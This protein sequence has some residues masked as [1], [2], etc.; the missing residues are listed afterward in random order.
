[1]LQ[2]LSAGWLTKMDAAQVTVNAD[3]A[4][5]LI[6]SGM[7]P[8]NLHVEGRLDLSG[9]DTR[10]RLPYGLRVRTLILNECS[11]L[12]TLPEG[13]QCYEIEARNSGLRSLPADIQ[14]VFKID[15]QGCEH[16]E[17]LPTGLKTGALVL[18]DCTGLRALPE[19]LDVYFLDISGC[20]R[21][22]EWPQDASISVG[23]LTA[24]GMTQITQLPVQVK[25]LAQLDIAGCSNLETLPQDLM[26][27]S[28]VDVAD[29]GVT[30]LPSSLDGLQVRWRGVVVEPRIAF[31]P[32]TITAREVLDERNA[33]VRR[34]MMERLGYEKFLADVEADVVHQDTDPGGVRRLLRIPLQGDEPLVCLAVLCPSTERQYV[35]R[36]PPT[37]KT[38]H[39]AAAWV[40]GFDNPDDYQPAIET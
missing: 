17:S 19:G 3:E 35:L 29:S 32:E 18:R 24:R 6:A 1:M 28:W 36:V 38:C 8:P 39:Q 7:A 30:Q 20:I 5:L 34:V 13:L 27:S 22:T 2:R 23:R 4:R 37:M 33:E 9:N 25:R 21:L 15:L 10:L 11:L 26:I 12:E 16:L 40:A 14:A 31:Q